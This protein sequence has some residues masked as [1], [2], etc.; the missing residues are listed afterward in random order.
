MKARDLQGVLSPRPGSNWIPFD[1]GPS[2]KVFTYIA[3]IGM[4]ELKPFRYTS[5]GTLWNTAGATVEKEPLYTGSISQGG[6]FAGTS[7]Q[8]LRPGYQCQANIVVFEETPRMCSRL[9]A[10]EPS[11]A[12]KVRECPLKLPRLVNRRQVIPCMQPCKMTPCYAP[13]TNARSL[14][15][16]R[17]RDST[18][19]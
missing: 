16:W 18:V 13:G 17:S 9:N 14:G 8:D 1:K 15:R 4:P 12:S 5:R 10:E 19:L 6:R 7:L 11:G 2:Y 3:L